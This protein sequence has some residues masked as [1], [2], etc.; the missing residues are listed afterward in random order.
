MPAAAELQ[1]AIDDA[2]PFSLY[3]DD[4]HG[5]PEHRQHL[6]YYFAEQIRAELTPEKG[7]GSGPHSQE[8]G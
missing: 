1:R 4:T 6:T 2:V 5:S 3:L 7:T 8:T